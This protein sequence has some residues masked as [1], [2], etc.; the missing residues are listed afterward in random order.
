MLPLLV[1]N[2][3]WMTDNGISIPADPDQETTAGSEICV[4]R[5][6]RLLGAIA[7]AVTVR[8]EAKPA[9]EAPRGGGLRGD[10]LRGGV[11]R[12]GALRG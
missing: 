12:A 9:I 8:P 2:Q 1:G 3:T 11:L 7:V 5:D 10:A 6:G 4:A